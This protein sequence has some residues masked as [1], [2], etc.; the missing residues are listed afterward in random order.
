MSACKYLVRS[1]EAYSIGPM[2]ESE[3]Q[4]SLCTWPDMHPDR[5]VNAP[6]WLLRQIGGGLAVMPAHDC[7]GCAAY[8]AR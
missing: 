7:V 5:F 8:C 6:R 4:V 2:G 3:V 1:E